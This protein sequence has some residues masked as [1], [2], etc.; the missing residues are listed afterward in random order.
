MKQEI[1]IKEMP[2]VYIIKRPSGSYES[3][4]EPIEKCF[5]NKNKANKYIE[6]ENKKLPLQQAEM[7]RECSFCWDNETIK[8]RMKP[9][10]CNWDKYKTC[11]NYFKYSDIYPLEIE[12]HNIEDLHDHDKE[13]IA[14]T[15]KKIRNY[16]ATTTYA[17]IDEQNIYEV[18]DKIQK[19]YE[20]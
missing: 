9:E 15:F 3:Y 11:Q 2:K 10:C 8:D 13:L 5:F 19:E 12:E 20:K 1:Y 6:S 16:F 17:S 14:K 18:L 4:Q 7:C